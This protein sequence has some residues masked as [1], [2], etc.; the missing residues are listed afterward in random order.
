MP[1]SIDPATY[2]IY[3]PQSYLTN[4][5]GTLYELDVEQFRLDLIDW[6]DS[7]DGMWMPRTHNHAS[8]VSLS[9]VVYARSVEIR[10]PYTIEFEDTGAPY[11]VRCAGA[12]HNIADVAVL[13][14]EVSLIVNN[15][16]GLVI[17][18]TG[19]S[20][21]TPGESAELSEAVIQ[22]TLARKLLHNKQQIEN[23]GG[24]MYLVTYDDDD[25]TVI[26]QQLLLTMM[27][28]MPTMGNKA[29]TKRSHGG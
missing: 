17:A 13:G 7:E 22:A 9:G 12:N 28:G 24:N 29:P 8:E 4:V 14:G 3:I 11:R 19:V 15:A 6:E 18:E 26:S 23:I 27:N 1:I 10:V 21:L 2:I 16:A 25:T 5:S 20:G